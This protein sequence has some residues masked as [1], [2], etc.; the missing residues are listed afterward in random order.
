[1]AAMTRSRRSTDKADGMRLSSE[2]RSSNQIRHASTTPCDSTHAATALEVTAGMAA[3]SE[4]M[5][6]GISQPIIF[7]G[8]RVA[9]LALAAPL[10]VAHTYANIVRHWVLS[11]LRAKREERKHQEHLIETEQQFRD[12]LEF[13]PA[14]ISVTDE[15]GRLIFHNKRYREILNYTKEEMDGI[16]TRRFWFNLH[17]RQRIMDILRSRN[18]NI[19]D[20]EILL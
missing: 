17:E 3:D 16:D 13:C 2:S 5:R 4:T 7:E 1:M 19:R 10:S 8:R 15:N 18:A 6:E 14:A 11:N 12:V 9:C 20:H